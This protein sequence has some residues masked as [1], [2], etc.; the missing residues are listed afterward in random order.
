MLFRSTAPLIRGQQSQITISGLQPLEK[1][2]VGITNQGWGNTVGIPLF[3]GLTFDL[4]DVGFG[5]LNGAADVNGT[6]ILHLTVPHDVPLGPILLQAGV[7]RGNRGKD[8]VKTIFV[9]SVIQD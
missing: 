3:G 8:S 5:I 6:A 2:W 9:E 7:A 4:A 1:T